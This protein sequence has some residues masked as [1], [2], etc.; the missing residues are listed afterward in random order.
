[1]R[2]TF[3]Q[4]MRRHCATRF[5]DGDDER[6][7]LQGISAIRT[8]E[9]LGL[10][11]LGTDAGIRTNAVSPG[12]RGPKPT[13]CIISSF[14]VP[15]RSSAA[16]MALQTKMSWKHPRGHRRRALAR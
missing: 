4:P 7:D 5:S 1:M 9:A 2:K 11:V 6:I 10:L 15:I 8:L 14:N 16:P 3:H 13:H 12:N